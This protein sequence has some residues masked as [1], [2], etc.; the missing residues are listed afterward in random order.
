MVQQS[1]KSSE[2]TANELVKIYVEM[3]LKKA[4]INLKR[5]GIAGRRVKI[6]TDTDIPENIKFDI[7]QFTA[8][9]GFD[10]DFVVSP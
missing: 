10:V 7:H 9:R 6:A 5:L 8:F 1:S 4:G 3:L 2:D